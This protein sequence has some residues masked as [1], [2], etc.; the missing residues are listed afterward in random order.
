[1]VGILT[2]HPA[3][4]VQ[5]WVRHCGGIKL[6]IEALDLRINLLAVLSSQVLELVDYD[7]R[8]QSIVCRRAV[9]L[10]AL[11]LDSTDFF[12]KHPGLILESVMA[13]RML[14]VELGVAPLKAAPFSA[15]SLDTSESSC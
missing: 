3:S 5:G 6:R 9:N 2:S 7:L 13:C 12:M 11:P 15:L 14:P 4:W 1:M 10:L 8:G